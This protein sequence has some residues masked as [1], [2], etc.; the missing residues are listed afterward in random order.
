VIE[1]NKKE[2]K[3]KVVANNSKAS[4]K[5][6]KTQVCK[7][8]NSRCIKKYCQCLK[9]FEY[10]SPETCG[11]VDCMNNPENEKVRQEAIDLIKAAPQKSGCNCKKNDCSK[12][13]CYCLANGLSCTE[14]CKCTEE[15]C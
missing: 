13:Y 9:F 1:E 7:C 4:P 10:C 15:E 12:K 14:A 11:C 5:P 8:T 2:R 6:R 3:E